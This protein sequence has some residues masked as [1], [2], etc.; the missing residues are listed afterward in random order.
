MT[1]KFRQLKQSDYSEFRRMCHALYREDPVDETITERKI[2]K[3]V[4]E[5]RKNPCK[6]RIIIFEEDDATIGYSIL[7]PYW[8]NE[9]GG[10]ILHIDELYVKPE[11]RQRGAAACFFQYIS[12]KFKGTIVGLELEVTPSNA[13]AMA[14]YRKLGFKKTRN[15]HLK[16]KGSRLGKQ[17]QNRLRKS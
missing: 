6:G 1:V 11:H 4:T 14:Y 17:L 16:R 10:D 2:S 12:R 5:L 8:S 3:T 7:I 15:A 9:Y 13:K